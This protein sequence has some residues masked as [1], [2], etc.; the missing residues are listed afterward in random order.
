MHAMHAQHL[1]Q[2]GNRKDSAQIHRFPA[3]PALNP[4]IY[5]SFL[6]ANHTVF[7]IFFVQAKLKA[8]EELRKAQEVLEAKQRAEE[9]ML[10]AVSFFTKMIDPNVHDYNPSHSTWVYFQ[11][12]FLNKII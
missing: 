10:L 4:V 6:L 7:L 8:R 11:R 5:H 1:F 2:M 3:F 9:D 12:F